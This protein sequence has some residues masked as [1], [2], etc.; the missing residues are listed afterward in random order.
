MHIF[1]PFPKMD[2]EATCL[3]VDSNSC[4]T[5]CVPPLSHSSSAPLASLPHLCMSV[6]MTMHAHALRIIYSG[7]AHFYRHARTLT[8][9]ILNG[10]D[11]SVV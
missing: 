4:D 5:L 11:K 10:L 2:N 3:I 1:W 8:G 6:Q 7:D 9:T